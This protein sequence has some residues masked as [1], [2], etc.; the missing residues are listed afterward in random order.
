MTVGRRD[1]L[2]FGSVDPHPTEVQ[3]LSTRQINLYLVTIKYLLHLVTHKTFSLS[4][5]RQKSRTNLKIKRT[6]SPFV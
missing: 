1:V 4:V 5:F 6:H 3:G 2:V